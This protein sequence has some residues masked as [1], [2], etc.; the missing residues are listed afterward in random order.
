MVEAVATAAGVRPEVIGKPAPHLFRV[1]LARL[2][3]PPEDAAMVGDS[4]NS[5]VR[6]AQGVGLR[7]IWIAPPGATSEDIRPDI[8][9]HHFDEL[10]GRL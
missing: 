5:D 2:G 7:T 3:V 1:A 8:T 9:I 6:G 4:L 10:T